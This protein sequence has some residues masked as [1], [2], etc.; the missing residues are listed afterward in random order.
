MTRGLWITC[1]ISKWC[2]KILHLQAVR[3]HMYALDSICNLKLLTYLCKKGHDS[4]NNVF[5]ANI[6]LGVEW[7]WSIAS[8]SN[9]FSR[10]D[11]CKIKSASRQGP[12]DKS[13][14][15]QS[16]NIPTFRPGITGFITSFGSTV[17]PSFVITDSPASSCRQRGDFNNPKVANFVLSSRP[18][19]SGSVKTYP[20]LGA[21]ISHLQTEPLEKTA[22]YVV[23]QLS[24]N[25]CK[26]IIFE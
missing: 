21:L 19:R 9:W 17:T 3:L 23:Y 1:R 24:S 11:S 2:N 13:D 15:L 16:P 25:Y 7:P 8:C 22:P 6:Y 10:V 14:E 18:V 26:R 12:T 4:T 5:K 20:K